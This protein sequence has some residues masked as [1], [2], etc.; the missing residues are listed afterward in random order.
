MKIK[1]SLFGR[2]TSDKTDSEEDTS[3][4]TND[5]STTDSDDWIYAYD[6][7]KTK[8]IGNIEIKS[9]G[10]MDHMD[11]NSDDPE[12]FAGEFP[13]RVM[14]TSL[15]RPTE[16]TWLGYSNHQLQDVRPEGIDFES[17]FRHI[18]IFGQTGFGKSTMLGTMMMQWVMSGY[19][20]C[21]FDQNGDDCE[22]LMQSIPEE[23]LDDVIW[24]EPGSDRDREVGI[25]FFEPSA[26][27]GDPQRDKQVRQIG[28]DFI[29]M[30]DIDSGPRMESVTQ[31][32]IS[33]LAKADENFTPLDFYRLIE[34]EEDREVFAEEFGDSF[35]KPALR[36]ISGMEED[37]LSPISRRAKKWVEDREA[38]S[39]LARKESTFFIDEAVQNGKI[40]LVNLGNIQ[41]DNLIQTITNT[42]MR[43]IWSTIQNRANM[44]E[45][46]RDP[47]FL[48]LDEFAS[49]AHDNMDVEEMLSQARK[50]RMSVTI[51][52]QQP[53]QIENDSIVQEIKNNCENFFTFKVGTTNIHEAKQIAEAL[54]STVNADGL[55]SLPKYEVVGKISGEDD[56]SQATTIN[57]FAPYPPLRSKSQTEQEILESLKKYGSADSDVGQ[58]EDYAIE[59]RIGDTND[60]S[61]GNGREPIVQSGNIKIYQE[62]ILECVHRASIK[63]DTQTI[64]GTEGW[65][66]YEDV[67][68]ELERGSDE[69][70]GYDTI[71]DNAIEKI[72]E[73]YMES[74]MYDSQLL[75]RLKP[76]GQ[77]AVFP[78]DTGSGGSAGGITHKQTLQSAYKTFIKLGYDTELPKQGGNEEKPDGI[79]QPPIKPGNRGSIEGM[80]KA[81]EQL[82]TEYP[83]VWNFAKDRTVSIESETSTFNRPMQ[84]L[85]NLKKAAEKGQK[86]AFV[87]QDGMQDGRFKSDEID[88]V[89]KRVEDI[90]KN[91]SCVEK[92]TDNYRQLYNKG[93]A[94]KLQDQVL[95]VHK[96][97]PDRGKARNLLWREN[98]NT[99]RL[100][101][102][103]KEKGEN[104]KI[105]SFRNLTELKGPARDKFNYYAYKDGSQWVVHNSETNSRINE[106]TSKKEMKNDWRIINEPFVP[107]QEFSEFSGR[108]RH[109]EQEENWDIIISPDESRESVTEPQLY[110]NGEMYP[111][112]SFFNDPERTSTETHTTGP[113]TDISN[114]TDEAGTEEPEPDSESETTEQNTTDDTVD[115]PDQFE[116]DMEVV[117]D[118]Q[119]SFQDNR[120]TKPESNDPD[121]VTISTEPTDSETETTET[122]NPNQK[123]LG[124][125]ESRTT[126]EKENVDT[127]TTEQEDEDTTQKQPIDQGT[128]ENED[129][130][131]DEEVDE[132]VDNILSG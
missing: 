20:M 107:E 123:T 2:F 86:C 105:T 15:K 99:G 128:P 45:E 64:D 37:E 127:T 47:F 19:G 76:E 98:L 100:E 24:I 80:K 28:E 119:V 90:I 126:S 117:R 9:F 109:P 17:L 10:Y 118:S 50:F 60:D 83:A 82:Q 81:K 14:N 8:K 110:R 12:V 40:V 31:S 63:T 84:T 57:T 30:L 32:L 72:P 112:Y 46:E 56:E 61:S 87:V 44:P 93:K 52:T 94:L 49:I 96:K 111:V 124:E 108:Q 18:A 4:A 88:V 62:D 59:K 51:C 103:L 85:Q 42:I 74:K 22:K 69:S 73:S 21:F 92:I 13:R 34:V 95:A 122:Q 16:S 130:D 39:V 68:A 43:R 53:S 115:K 66:D 36:K 101:L 131:D 41:S 7:V 79:A 23:R 65:V 48:V 54:G 35:E 33:Q 71:V 1:D 26:D 11:P 113:E 6:E 132:L 3:N 77:K 97:D 55:L 29:E 70:L 102:S 125:S 27:K 58:F 120:K 75:L 78:S 129:D 114:T 89:A 91:P 104:T 25:N 67:I 121:T 106:Y 38:R 5:N 116:L